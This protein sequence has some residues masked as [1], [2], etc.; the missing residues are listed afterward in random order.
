MYLGVD[1][2]R[3]VDDADGLDIGADLQHEVDLLLDGA[4]VA[5]SR[6]V[7][8]GLLV[9]SGELRADVVRDR[10]A[11]DGNVVRRVRHALCGGR[12]DRTD[13]IHLRV[14]E[15]LRNV[16]QVRLIGLRVLAVNG[17]VFAFLEAALLESV[18]EA[19]VRRIERI[20]LD[21]LHDADLHVLR[22]G[23]LAAADET[24]ARCEK[25]SAEDERLELFGNV[26]EDSAFLLC[27]QRI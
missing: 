16:L 25:R 7:A 8:A 2:A 1:L 15:T 6:D 21:E 11:D 9:R 14:D 13:E 17:D 26:H 3:A 18:G 10:R 5:C 23:A 27:G 24:E 12:R 19:L 20:V 4:H 22:V